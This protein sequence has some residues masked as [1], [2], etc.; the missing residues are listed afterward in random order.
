MKIS[1]ISGT[2]LFIFINFYISLSI[3]Y[4]SSYYSLITFINFILPPLLILYSSSTSVDYSISKTS[5]VKKSLIF[6]SFTLL[7]SYYILTILRYI[8]LTN[9]SINFEIISSIISFKFLSNITYPILFL[10]FY[11][12]LESL[13]YKY[14]IAISKNII[15]AFLIGFS[16]YIFSL[17]IQNFENQNYLIQLLVGKKSSSIFPLLSYIFIQIMILSSLINIVNNKI[18]NLIIIF[19]FLLIGILVNQLIKA[20]VTPPNISYLL[21]SSGLIM[22]F[23]NFYQFIYTKLIKFKK[24]VLFTT[25]YKYLT[26]APEY[27]IILS[28]L[29][30]ILLSFILKDI[31]IFLSVFISLILSNLIVAPNNLIKAGYERFIL[32]RSTNKR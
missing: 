4:N 16:I 25:F 1:K 2:I 7:A 6:K 23:I 8:L 29:I 11:F 13:F 26:F 31:N 27:K 18:K 5:V 24:S 21:L 19:T 17:T 32:Y 20:E 9:G 15:F 12:M 30:L 3:F 22:I 28:I 14:L 10:A